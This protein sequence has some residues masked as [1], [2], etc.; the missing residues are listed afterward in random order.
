MTEGRF[1]DKIFTKAVK[2]LNKHLPAERKTLFALLN[3]QKN[4]I[5][6]FAITFKW[7][8]T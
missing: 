8:Q 4:V 5:A 6:E 7:I 3:D 1:D 2:A